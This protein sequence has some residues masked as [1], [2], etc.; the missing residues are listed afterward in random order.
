MSRLD[1]CQKRTSPVSRN[2]QPLPTMPWRDAGCPVSSVAC[3]VQVTAGTASASRRS[4]PASARPFRRGACGSRREVS[5]TAFT[6]TSGC[7]GPLRLRLSRL[8]F[9]YT[10][11]LMLHHLV[12]G[13]GGTG[14]PSLTRGACYR[15]HG[16]IS[17]HQRVRLDGPPRQ[18]GRPDQRR[19]SGS[20]LARRSHQSRRLRN[21][22]H[23]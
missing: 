23:H 14:L 15:E 12:A 5:P 1:C 16:S 10:L 3:A 4:Q 8:L 13:D 11:T 7:M 17:V 9:F 19:H 18:G 21:A 2:S 20:L 22:R 6:S